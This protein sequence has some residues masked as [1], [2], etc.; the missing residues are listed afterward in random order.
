MNLQLE[1]CEP[2]DGIEIDGAASM[3]ASGDSQDD[4]DRQEDRERV[5]QFFETAIHILNA[6][7]A[8]QEGEAALRMSFRCWVLALGFRTA[9]GAE[10]PS[11]LARACGFG[12][13]TVGKCLNHFIA[14]LRLAPLPGQRSEDGRKNMAGAR[15]VQVGPQMPQEEP[16]GSSAMTTL[17]AAES[18]QGAVPALQGN[19]K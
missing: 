9:A 5:I 16:S 4:A 14:Q 17:R 7:Q 1:E 6:Y 15:R 18:L 8:H 10:G 11:E 19:G 12:K 3:L 2:I 13:Q